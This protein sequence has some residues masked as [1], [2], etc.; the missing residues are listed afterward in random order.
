MNRHI[1]IYN[2]KQNWILFLIVAAVLVMYFTVII[3]M[4]DPEGNDDLMQLAAM[5][6]S[7]D[8]LKAFGFDLISSTDLCC[9]LSSYLYGMLMPILAFIYSNVVANRLISG[10][11][12]KGDIVLWLSSPVSRISIAI[13]QAVF[14]WI[15]TLML[16]IFITVYSIL[17]CQIQFPGKLD[18]VNYISLN[19]GFMALMTLVSGI[20][21]LASAIFDRSGLSLSVGIGVPLLFYVFKMI[22]ETGNDFF[23]DI[24]IFSLFDNAGLASGIGEWILPCV[25]A[26]SGII[27]YGTGVLIFSK[28]DLSV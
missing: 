21:F 22:G 25:A 24:T 1:F 27:L 4:F 17:L 13:T 9:F 15:S 18:I 12:S 5:K 11:I 3:G 8:M 6:M 20:G 14:L 7:P 28:K 26:I 10:H 2:T 19:L 23:S 16:V